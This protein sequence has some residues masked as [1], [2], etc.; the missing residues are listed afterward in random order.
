[1]FSVLVGWLSILLWAASPASAVASWSMQSTPNPFAQQNVLSRVDCVSTTWCMAVGYGV[2]TGSSLGF[3]ASWN[4]SSWA[5]VDPGVAVQLADTSC[6]SSTKCF[7]VGQRVSLS[8]GHRLP[9]LL[10]WSGVGWTSVSL[11]V[12]A[13]QQFVALSGIECATGTACL[14]VGRSS[15]GSGTPFHTLAYRYNGTTWARISSPNPSTAAA[16]NTFADVSC[17]GAS[18]CFVAGTA[19]TKTLVEQWTGGTA[20]RRLPTPSPRAYNNFR[21]ISCTAITNCYVVGDT[22]TSTGSSN[23]FAEQYNGTSWTTH[24]FAPSNS[25]L[26]DISCVS[27]SICLAVG[28]ASPHTLSVQHTAAGWSTL[29]SPNPGVYNYLYGISCSTG[30]SCEGVGSSTTAT[31]NSNSLAAT[32]S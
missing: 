10:R 14:A 18:N 19:G 5:A 12:P 3:A 30:P 26:N 28:A 4:G 17:I 13:G 25:F 16:G 24:T 21:A 32:Y 15:D 9:A 31:S 6:V 1:M 7:A 27:A 11:S 22:T 23:A 29:P 2:D 8:T 20:W